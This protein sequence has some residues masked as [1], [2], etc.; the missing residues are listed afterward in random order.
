VSF[1]AALRKSRV[2]RYDLGSMS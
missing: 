1:D 2:L